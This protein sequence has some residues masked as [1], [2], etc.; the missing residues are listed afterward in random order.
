MKNTLLL[1]SKAPETAQQIQHVF[2]GSQY[3]IALSSPTTPIPAVTLEK[4][5]LLLLVDC[6]AELLQE[7]N[8]LEI[9]P[10]IPALALGSLHPTTLNLQ[11]NSS[12]RL[13]DYLENYTDSNTLKRKISFLK[14]V[15]KL[16]FEHASYLKN[17]DAFLDLFT[18]R[19]GLTGLYNRHHFNKTL[20]TEYRAALDN[21][22]DLS[23][24]I[25]DIDFFNEINKTCGQN[26]GDFVLNV[27]SSRLTGATRSE[28]ICFRLSGG[29]FVVLMPGGDL[30]TARSIGEKIV[31][32]CTEKPFCRNE[33]ERQLT[34]SIGI[35]SY[36]THHPATV[37]EFVNMAETAL[38]KAKADGRDRVYIYAPR[39]ANSQQPAHNDFDSIKV[40]INRVLEKTRHSAITSLQLLARD[41]AGPRHRDH[42]D[43]VSR[44]T[45]LL[46]TQIGLTPAIIRTLQNSSILYTSIRH[47]IH[48]DLLSKKETFSTQDREIIKDFPYK[49]SEVVDIFDYFSQE[50]LI[51]LT[52]SEKFDGSGYPEGLK[53]DEIPLGARIVSIVDSFAAMEADRPYR[54]KFQPEDILSELKKE[55]GKQF[56]PF[57]VLKLLDTIEKYSLL[58]IPHAEITSIRAE[59]LKLYN[60][61]DS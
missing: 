60:N 17:Y 41:I 7:L 34:L 31:N 39:E 1:F 45:E 11:E 53:G 16:N 3:E 43:R 4:V 6:S 37:D 30:T 28:D 8:A 51:L 47:L 5:F 50:R 44:Y 26:F 22:T 18:S 10:H 19:D 21:C 49:L 35:A 46:C 58:D 38:F 36:S 20:H 54:E 57:L 14:K 25:I 15:A 2:Q 12:G 56:D 42:I 33:I 40:T 61:A 24:L 23:I 48:N 32:D 27:M 29:D 59:L 13:I 52:R 9:P 55:A